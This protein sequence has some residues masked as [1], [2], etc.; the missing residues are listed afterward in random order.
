MPAARTTA[1]V[2]RDNRKRLAVFCD[3]TWNDLRMPSLTNVARLAKCVSREGWDGRAQVVF[4]DAG[5]GVSTGVS[6]LVDR[7]V[8]L[9]GGAL[10]RGIDEKIE[11]AY[12]FLV[13]NYEPGDEIF[14]FGFSRGAY[15][16]RSLVGL[17]R[18]CGIVRR[19]CFEQIPEAL[20][21]YRSKAAPSDS[22]LINFRA[23]YG[24]RV[25]GTGRPIATGPEDLSEA[26]LDTARD[27]SGHPPDVWARRAIR[28]SQVDSEGAEK[29][30]PP[31][32]PPPLEIYRMMYVGLWDTV[33]SLGLPPSIPI[34]SRLLNRKYRFHDTR[35]SSLISSLRHAC[36][37]DE[38]RK[39]FDITEVT[40][41]DRLNGEW[42][43]NNGLQ[44]DYADRPGF[45]QPWDR[46]FQQ[47]WFPGGHGSVG[48]GNPERGLSSGA[49]VWVAVGALRA[50]LKFEWG[51][52]SELAKAKSERTPFADWRIDK[53]GRALPPWAFDFLGFL[54]GYRDR[55]G[56][57]KPYELSWAA[58]TRMESAEA[59]YRPRTLKRFTGSVQRTPLYRVVARVLGVL[60]WVGIL[61]L[62]ALLFRD[63]VCDATGWLRAMLQPL[64]CRGA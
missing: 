31:P 46:P 2:P 41:I 51:G 55:H 10:G 35:A 59:N 49:L 61:A 34:L 62:L 25:P 12:R 22:E 11:T 19:D 64:C 40:N 37:L 44:I 56:P 18:K 21:L 8:G 4:Y 48:G 29:E 30:V 17:I 42:A 47:C 54:T 57:T 32:E 53:A 50:G 26:P 16:A 45:V 3:G 1:R 38:D 5:V 9:L 33:G 60:V 52:N 24:A 39:V 20:R 6:P 7:L 23:S 14:V 58:R 28:M 63:Q 27:A 43:I 15:T 36:A 13:L